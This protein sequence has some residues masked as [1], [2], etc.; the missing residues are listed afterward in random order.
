MRFTS[1]LYK[2]VDQAKYQKPQK[3][4][5]QSTESR[6]SLEG[7]SQTSPIDLTNEDGG[8]PGIV[9]IPTPNTS[10]CSSRRPSHMSLG[11]AS[12]SGIRSN[13]KDFLSAS[14]R[15]PIALP[16]YRSP[17]VS[18][19]LKAPTYMKSKLTMY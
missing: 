13:D 1:L 17:A 15:A 9:R 11:Q 10:A 5:Q 18:P 19:S 8:I 16:A 2:V 14:G 12:N 4:R 3:G 7:Y 6:Q